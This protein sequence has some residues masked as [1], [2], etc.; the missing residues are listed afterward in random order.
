MSNTDDFYEEVVVNLVLGRVVS[1]GELNRVL[2]SVGFDLFYDVY[3][4]ARPTAGPSWQSEVLTQLRFFLDGKPNY[5]QDGC[6]CIS[7]VYPLATIDSSM[8]EPFVDILE[9]VQVG[10]GGYLYM[11]NRTVDRQAIVDSLANTVSA[12]LRDWS[13]EPG[14]KT[15]RIMIEGNYG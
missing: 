10:L 9:R 2:R 6:D 15:L 12:L 5:A 14:S 7:F 4:F 3:A 1:S 11:A 13:E 8:I